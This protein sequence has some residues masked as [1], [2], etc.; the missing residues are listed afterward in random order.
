MM[1]RL[2]SIAAVMVLC[3]AGQVFGLAP[4]TDNQSGGQNE[5]KV[6][7]RKEVDQPAKITYKSEVMI[8]EEARRHSYNGSAMVR[9]VLGA[10]GKVRQVE[11]LDKVRYGMAE[12]CAAAARKI[13][14]EPALKDGRTVSQYSMIEYRWSFY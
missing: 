9:V 3:Y 7:T 12:A 10:D 4:Q 5:E 6:Y 13:E 11:V 14:F 1:K 2:I 8:T